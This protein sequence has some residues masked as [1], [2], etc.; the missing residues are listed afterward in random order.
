M[1]QDGSSVTQNKTID[2]NGFIIEAFFPTKDD[3]FQA[4]IVL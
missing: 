4:L 1:F 3:G 2:L